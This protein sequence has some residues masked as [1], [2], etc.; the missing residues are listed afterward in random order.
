MSTCC[1]SD[2][3]CTINGCRLTACPDWTQPY[4]PQPYYPPVY[5]TFPT[6]PQPPAVQ[7]VGWKCPNCGAGVSPDVDICSN[8]K[9]YFS[10]ATTYI[11]TTPTTE[12]NTNDREDST[13]DS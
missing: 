11:A 2:P 6:F 5:P 7:P 4:Y 3:Y 10:F 12:A 1:C 13:S 8:C 9:P